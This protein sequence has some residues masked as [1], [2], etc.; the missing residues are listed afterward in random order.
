[1]TCN[2]ISE[3][4]ESVAL[5]SVLFDEHIPRQ[6]FRKHPDLKQAIARTIA[7]QIENGLFKCKF[8]TTLRWRG[9]PV[10]ECRVNERSVGA[11]RV[12]FTAEGRTCTVLFIS[13]TL[14]KRAFTAELERSLRKD[15][16]A[17]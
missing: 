15:P 14:Q 8:A 6:W 2:A 7:D 13:S 17:K 16:R 11:V 12:A 1:M 9:A 10:R 4:C 3:P 5:G